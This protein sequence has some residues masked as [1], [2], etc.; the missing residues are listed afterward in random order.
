MKKAAPPFGAAWA[1]ALY[2]TVPGTTGL[3]P[4]AIAK[5]T[6]EGGSPLPPSLAATLGRDRERASIE[7]TCVRAMKFGDWAV[8]VLPDWA[9]ALKKGLARTFPAP[10]MPLAAGSESGTF[11]Y[12]GEP[13]EAG[14]YPVV[15]IDVDDVPE[16]SIAFGGYDAWLASDLGK[17]RKGSDPRIVGHAKRCFGGKKRARMS[18][19]LADVF[20]HDY[21][22]FGRA[23]TKLDAE[24]LRGVALKPAPT[25]PGFELFFPE[26]PDRT[27]DDCIARL[28]PKELLD[29][30]VVDGE[31]IVRGDLVDF[32]LRKF[33][34]THLGKLT[35]IKNWL[36]TAASG[37]GAFHFVARENGRPINAWR[38][39]VKAQHVEVQRLAIAA[40]DAVLAGPEYAA[41]AKR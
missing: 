4:A 24:A 12:L 23:R 27:L 29:V 37:G 16:W 3:P 19:V 13:D 26:T 18:P 36:W 34:P 1:H 6:F 25:T 40:L 17:P 31:A 10:C 22:V 32:E 8:E 7:G 2:E 11:L 39:A 30:S 14:E 20:R 33:V 38:V 35:T 21:V 5:L 9:D 15:T 41:I 28:D